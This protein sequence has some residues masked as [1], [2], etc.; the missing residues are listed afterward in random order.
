MTNLAISI[1]GL[2]REF[3][4][5]YDASE[6]ER[7][8]GGEGPINWAFGS[9]PKPFA[10]AREDGRI[11]G[12]SAYILSHM[13]YGTVT[14]TGLQAVDSFVSSDMRGRGV[15][16]K[17]A[18][19]YDDHAR[20]SGADLVWGFPNDNAAPAWFGKLGW[21]SHGQV[22]FLVKPLR[23]GFFLR[24]LGLPI[25]FPVSFSRDQHLVEVTEI[26]DWAD[27]LWENISPAIGCAS[28]RDRQFM[29][30][31]LINAPQATK[32]RIVADTNPQS[33][34]VV[35]T[36]EASKHGGHIAYLMEALGGSSM[37]ELL[38]SEIGRL[39]SRGVELV[40]A[41]SFPW[42]P[43]YRVLRKAGFMPLPQR[44]RPI[45][46]W[47]GNKPQSAVAACANDPSQWYLS[48][49]DSDTV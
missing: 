2:S 16:T 9:N 45:R 44:V 35:A 13:K 48:Y 41:W 17:L 28:V 30:H 42:S 20:Q 14:G 29:T 1:E 8:K 25:D 11:V 46:I 22:P 33:V 12:M 32:Y 37:V 7:G 21:Q 43:N 31:R 3:I 36:C 38:M 39:R 6:M 23:A 27:R 34:S 26:G 49:L 24:K 40:L 18:R 47:F 15:F 4:D 19:A 10:V 5:A